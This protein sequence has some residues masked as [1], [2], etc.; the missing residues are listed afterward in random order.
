MMQINSPVSV[1]QSLPPVEVK[2]VPQI[3]VKTMPHTE[4]SVTNWKSVQTVTQQPT[5]IYG[6]NDVVLNGSTQRIDANP[7]RQGLILQA[8]EGNQGEIVIQS[9]LRVPAGAVVEFPASN[10]VTV[11]GIAGDVLHIG[12]RV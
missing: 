9:F 8:D 11:E 12:E 7:K 4:V 5:E 10:A 3:E 2:T 1:V 6:R